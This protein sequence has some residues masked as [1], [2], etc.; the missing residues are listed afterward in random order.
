[1]GS[2]SDG[3]LKKSS[4]PSRISTL[5]RGSEVASYMG[6]RPGI[7]SMFE[8]STRGRSMCPGASE[9]DTCAARWAAMVGP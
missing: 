5:F 9:N 4:L 1:M 3:V 2:L 8:A 7:I 6:S